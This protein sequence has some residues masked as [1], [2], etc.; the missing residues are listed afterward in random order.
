MSQWERENIVERIKS[1]V[2]VRAKL[3][4]VM[5]AIPF[6]YKKVGKDDMALDEH[7]APIRKLMYEL[8]LEHRRYGTVAQILNERGYHTK[9]KKPFSGTT[10]KRLLKDPTAKGIRRSHCTQVNAEGKTIMRDEKEWYTHEAPRIVSD[11]LW[12]EVNAIIHKQESKRIQPLNKKVHLFTGY[13][14]CKCGGGMYVPSTNP[15]YTCK[16]CKSKIHV[17]D[18]EAIFKEQLTEFIVSESEVKRYFDGTHK[19]IASKEQEI[20]LV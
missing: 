1:S 9:R 15:K 16:K 12:D 3:G 7:E 10:I 18:I 5:G 19:I 14:F 8:F 20:E 2:E 6:G 4:K 17:E 11:E 13:L